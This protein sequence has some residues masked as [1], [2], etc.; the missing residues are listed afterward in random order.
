[1]TKY[2]NSTQIE[3]VAHKDGSKGFTWNPIVGCR[4]DCPYCYAAALCKRFA[5]PWDRDPEDPFKPRFYPERLDAPLKLKKP[6]KIFMMSMGELWGHWVPD[7]WKCKIMETV[8]QASQHTF[9]NL[10]KSTVCMGDLDDTR[11]LPSNY[12]LGV[13]V[14]TMENTIFLERLRQVRHPNKFVSFEPL[15]ENV[16]MGKYFTLEGV[17]WVII[18]AQTGPGGHQPDPAWTMNIIADAIQRGIPIF[19]KDNM[20]WAPGKADYR[21]FPEGFP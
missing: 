5:V 17:K 1:M 11:P 3:W 16:A 20:R 10:T 18:G 8:R 2:L 19:M 12:W 6:S 13:S 7:H 21:A 15:L 14:D 9:L 4:R